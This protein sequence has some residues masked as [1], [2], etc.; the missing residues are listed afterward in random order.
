MNGVCAYGEGE[1]GHVE[2]AKK[3]PR[4]AGERR[5]HFWIGTAT[6][7]PV[8]RTQEAPLIVPPS[9]EQ[10][11]RIGCKSMPQE[12]WV[13]DAKKLCLPEEHGAARFWFEGGG[14]E[15]EAG[16]KLPPRQNRTMPVTGW[17]H[18]DHES[19][20]TNE[21]FVDDSDSTLGPRHGDGAVQFAALI[22]KRSSYC[23]EGP[24]KTTA[25]STIF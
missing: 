17:Q 13:S 2:M 12:Y 4:R 15:F 22:K 16:V 14:I 23:T 1:K 11:T 9:P 5:R 3:T 18:H 24:A 21:P 10:S 19:R 6:I 8:C 20:E 25:K 7:A